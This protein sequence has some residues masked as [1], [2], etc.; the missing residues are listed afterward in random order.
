MMNFLNW[1]TEW[2]KPGSVRGR[3]VAE[4]IQKQAPDLACFSEAYPETLPPDGYLISSSDD[5][6]YT[7]D[8]GRRKVFLWSREPWSEEWR[9][10]ETTLPGGRFVSGVTTGIRCVG[11]CIPWRMAHVNTGHRD[12]KP[13]E[14]HIVYL[15]ALQ[16]ILAGFLALPEPLLVT[17][18]WNQRI[19]RTR[20]PEEA[21]ELLQCALAGLEVTSTGVPQGFDEPLIDHLA[22]SPKIQCSALDPIPSRDSDGKPLSDHVGFTAVIESL[23]S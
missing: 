4:T 22:V 2:A 21:S 7:N 12:R 17:G 14:D 13:W 9:A 11:L 8:G 23:K 20:Q 15:E 18:D 10:E 1:N 5:T 6:G 3:R 16:S 19:P